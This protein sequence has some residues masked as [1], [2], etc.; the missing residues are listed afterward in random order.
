MI[1]TKRFYSFVLVL[2]LGGVLLISATAQAEDGELTDA[3]LVQIRSRCSEIKVSLNRIHANDALLRVNRGQLYERLSTK[4]AAPL[5]SRIALNRL[6]GSSLLSVTS[7]YELNLNEFRTRY[8]AYEEQLST[9]MR[10]DCVKQP[11]SFY[12]NLQLARE[13]RRSVYE[14]TQKLARNIA[15]YKQAFTDFAK[16]YR[17]GQS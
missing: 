5:N 4:L 15:D 1:T 7:S 6:D 8:Q 17:E 13:K 9:T 3:K 2:A 11:A 12:D 10:T 14:S 16:S